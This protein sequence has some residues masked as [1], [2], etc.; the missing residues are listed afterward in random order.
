M[1]RAVASLQVDQ[2]R[3]FTQGRKKKHCFPWLASRRGSFTNHFSRDG[4][5]TTSASD[6]PIRAA[7]TLGHR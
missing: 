3:V 5:G 4:R 6:A 7:G 1:V 2:Y